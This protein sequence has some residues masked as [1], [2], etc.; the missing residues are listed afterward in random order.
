MTAIVL[1]STN[2]SIDVGF[3]WDGLGS[4]NLASVT[5]AA[6]TGLTKVSESTDTD[7]GTSMVRLSGLPME[8]CT[9]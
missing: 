6:P 8:G 5:H 9:R 2:D 7:A 4:A 1:V 3:T